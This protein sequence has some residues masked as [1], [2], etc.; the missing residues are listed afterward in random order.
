MSYMKGNKQLTK[1]FVLNINKSKEEPLK[2]NPELSKQ[3]RP[4][5]LRVP[6]GCWAEQKPGSTSSGK[7]VQWLVRVTQKS[8]RSFSLTQLNLLVGLQLVASSLGWR[9]VLWQ[10]EER[11]CQVRLQQ[12]Q[13]VV[14]CIRT[15]NGHALLAAARPPGE[16]GS[17]RKLRAESCL[18]Q[19]DSC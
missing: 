19:S 5:C 8:L 7:R 13:C 3:S 16:N 10:A 18:L 4:V 12:Q 1:K 14:F 9:C 2:R 6:L 15:H 11:R 17:C